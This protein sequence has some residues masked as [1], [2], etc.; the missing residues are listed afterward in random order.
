MNM[1]GYELRNFV[2]DRKQSSKWIFLIA[3]IIGCFSVTASSDPVFRGEFIFPEQERHVHSSCVVECSDGSLLAC[4]FRGS[5]ERTA[6]D[7]LIQGAR[8]RKGA[9]EW[10]EPFLM[11]DTPDIPD[12]NPVM[13]IDGREQLWLFWIAVPADRWE[14]S[15]LRYRQSNNYMN[16][17]PPVWSW[18]DDLILKPGDQFAE[19]METGYKAMGL[20]DSDYGGYAP[21]PFESLV[22]T[23]KNKSNR[24]K[25]WMPRTHLIVLPGGRIL[26]PLYSDGFYVGLMAISDDDGKTWRASSP[27]VGSCLNQP[28]V[29]RKQDGTLVAYM[30]SEGVMKGRTQISCSTDEGETWSNAKKTDIPNP[31]SSLEA[32]ALNDGRWVMVYNDTGDGRHSL[33]VS[34]SD[35]EGN[36]WKWTRHLERREG[37]MFHYPSIIQS[38]DGLIHITYTYQMGENPNRTIKHVVL[39]SD[40]IVESK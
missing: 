27:I 26:L 19:A 23:A 13:F 5:G 11:A 20:L 17:G 9:K 24:Q 22:E 34:L 6:A 37:G 14:D 15:L 40:W 2:R 1:V 36:S 8:L 33:A 32:I 28:S 29:V 35:D 4:W 38:R 10:S 39:N 12:C 7:V 31:N 3:V 25:G 30:R 21:D 18:Q 16:D